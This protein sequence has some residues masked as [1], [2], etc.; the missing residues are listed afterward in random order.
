[1]ALTAFQA[2][3]EILGRPDREVPEA[4][5]EGRRQ[6]EEDGRRLE[7]VEEPDGFLL[8]HDQQHLGPDHLSAAGKQGP[9]TCILII[10]TD[11]SGF[12]TCR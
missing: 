1:L 9:G 6:G 12:I 10:L 8:P 2:R 3:G 5:G 11:S 7:G 4:S